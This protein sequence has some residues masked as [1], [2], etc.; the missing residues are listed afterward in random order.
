MGQN[1]DVR[2]RIGSD[3]KEVG[4]IGIEHL[5]I[6]IKSI[7]FKI[8]LHAFPHFFYNAVRIQFI[9]AVKI[10]RVTDFTETV[11][12]TD[13]TEGASFAAL[14]NDICDRTAETPVDIM[15]FKGDDAPGIFHGTDNGGLVNRFDG[16]NITLT[17]A[18]DTVLTGPVPDQA[19]LY[20]LL[21]KVR[22]LGLPLRSLHCLSQE[23][24]PI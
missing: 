6:Q 3:K 18:G 20:G 11:R 1:V 8:H 16:M 13:F 19:A 2:C 21:T 23:N 9:M 24:E 12:N 7:F 4:D 15:L 5:T 22:D 14:C 17:E 10:F